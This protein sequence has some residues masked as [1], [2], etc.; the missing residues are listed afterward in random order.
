MTASE[1]TIYRVCADAVKEAREAAD[2]LARH[3]QVLSD[4]EL[5][6]LELCAV[7]VELQ[8]QGFDLDPE[9]FH[10]AQVC[11]FRDMPA[12]RV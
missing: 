10:R 9:F 11:I 7:V 6:N 1:E 8:K 4:Y 2:L 3:G 12:Y 5:V